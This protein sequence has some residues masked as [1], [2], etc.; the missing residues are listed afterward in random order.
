[1]VAEARTRLFPM[2]LLHLIHRIEKRLGR[3]RLV[4]KGP[5]TIDIDILLFGNAI[6]DTGGL[7]IPHPAL[8]GRGFVLEP[9]AELAPDL[10]H[11]RMRE[12]VNEMLVRVRNQKV[13]LVSDRN[14]DTPEH[15]ADR[16]PEVHPPRRG[17]GRPR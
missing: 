2:Q 13:E 8:A 6:V 17:P 12:S 7:Q 15:V 11:P 3:R 1:M 4:V 16:L 14:A 9:L 5:R 10:R